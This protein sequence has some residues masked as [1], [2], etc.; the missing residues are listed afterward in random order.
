VAKECDAPDSILNSP[1]IYKK[2]PLRDSI[3]E[4]ITVY[5]KEAFDFI[6]YCI[7][8]NEKIFIHCFL[9]HSRSVAIAV[10]YLMIKRAQK[11]INELDASMISNKSYPF[12][13]EAL[14]Q[15]Q[16]KR[17]F[18]S[19]NL[20]FC[21]QLH[22]L[23][24]KLQQVLSICLNIFNISS[25]HDRISQLEGVRYYIG[26]EGYDRLICQS[27]IIAT[28]ESYDCLPRTI[29]EDVETIVK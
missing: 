27:Y 2:I 12:Y 10:S 16:E 9:G 20:A 8:N 21:C 19:P 22:N 11:A 28:I 15:I 18:A 25:H 23:D 26:T 24:E 14:N 6:E 3:E 17:E 5:F 29:S 7:S 13:S 4:D 1:F